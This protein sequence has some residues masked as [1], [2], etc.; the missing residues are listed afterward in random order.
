MA[1]IAIKYKVLHPQ[2]LGAL[3]LRSA[4]DLT[5]ALVHDVE[6]AWA[7]GLKASMLTLDVQGAFDAVLS[8]RLVGRL[9]EQGWLTKVIRWMA[10]FT[11]GRT[12]SLRLGTHT[13]KTYDIPA[14]LP[15]G[16]PISPILFML[17]IEPI[18]KQGT[19]RTRRG[20]FG[21]ADDICQLVASPSLEENCI[22]LQ[23]CTEELRQWGAREGLTFDFNKTELQHF[24]QGTNHSNPSCSV[25]TPHDIQIIN[26]PP[27]GGATR[28]LGIWFDRRMN[29]GKHCRTLAAKAKQ[30]AA[31]IKSLANTVRGA[32]ALLLRHATVACVISVLC[33][34]A[35]A[36]WPGRRRPRN[37]TYISNRVDSALSWLDRVLREALRGTLPV[38]RTTPTSVLHRETAIPP[39]EIILDQKRAAARLRTLDWMINIQSSGAYPIHNPSLQIHA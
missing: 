37:Q 15:Q 16:S 39:I 27:P 4:T 7:R 1:W 38:Y 21:Y 31:G 26:P 35:E 24:S 20:R 12:A 10:S 9:R 29:F 34:G 23:H 2:Q 19:N 36:W 5:A 8:G 13:S 25:H 30:I 14:G 33:Y 32:R 3:P 11:Q 6:E 28:W 18:F 22:T 17:F